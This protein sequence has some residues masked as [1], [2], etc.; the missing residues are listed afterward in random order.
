MNFKTLIGQLR[1]LA[2]AEGIS[3]L[4]LALT[5]PLKYMYDMPMPNKI[6]GMAHGVLFI[7]YCVWVIVVAND[8][9][10][11]YKTTFLAGLA[12]LLPFGTFVADAKIFKK[13]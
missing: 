9:K 13:Y 10:W 4:L 11:N 5:M 12:S 3:Y 1:I 6:V 2:I 8:K 7:A